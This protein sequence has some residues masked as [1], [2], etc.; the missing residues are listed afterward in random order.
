MNK[1]AKQLNEL[2]QQLTIFRDL[3]VSEET[4]ETAEWPASKDSRRAREILSRIVNDVACIEHD[5]EWLEKSL[6]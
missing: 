2:Q 6:N 4:S 3:L 5:L 1:H